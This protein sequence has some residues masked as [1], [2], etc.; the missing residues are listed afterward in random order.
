M[1]CLPPSLHHQLSNRQCQLK[2]ASVK[3][4]SS[5]VFRVIV[6]FCGYKLNNEER[7][8]AK[9][10]TIASSS[11]KMVSG[12]VLHQT[13]SKICLPAWLQVDTH[14]GFGTRINMHMV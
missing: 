1:H 6:S 9:L 11:Y 10:A 3:L 2:P 4:L 7:M 14:F 8:T 5:T 13:S 12:F